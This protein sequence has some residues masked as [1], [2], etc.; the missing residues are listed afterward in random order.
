MN[1]FIKNRLKSIGYAS[2]GA[3]L[4]IT[5]E[6]SIQ[7]QTTIA[8]LVCIA[9]FIF[10]ISATEWCIQLITIAVI[11]GAEG[12]N[13]AIEKL[14]DFVH[15]DY[16]KVIGSVKDLAAGAVFLTAIIAIIIGLI[17]YIPKIF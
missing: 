17:I 12:L 6:P 5:T 1:S 16:H 9:G 11:L 7:V 2:K 14:S 4:L 13:T 15:P 3:Y 10:D 8:I